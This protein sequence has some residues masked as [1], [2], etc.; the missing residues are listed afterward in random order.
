MSKFFKDKTDD[1]GFV[2]IKEECAKFC[3]SSVCSH[4]FENFAGD[5]G[6]AI[7]LNRQTSITRNTAKEGVAT[8]ATASIRGTEVRGVGVYIDYHVTSTISYFC[9]RMSGHVFQE[10][11]Y[12][13]AYVFSSNSYLASDSR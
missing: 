5:I 12:A 2:C 13:V 10:L 11:V 3:L 6:S 1:L 4:Q 7:D 8:G 9:I